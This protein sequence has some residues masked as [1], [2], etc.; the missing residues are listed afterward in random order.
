MLTV[1]TMIAHL[2][3]LSDQVAIATQLSGEFKKKADILFL[4]LF[5]AK[6]SQQFMVELVA[7]FP[8]NHRKS[9][10]YS[11]VGTRCPGTRSPTPLQD[12]SRA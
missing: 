7:E 3:R 6:L 9:T 11:G 10:R 4:A 1:A 8:E 5:P 12:S 2:A